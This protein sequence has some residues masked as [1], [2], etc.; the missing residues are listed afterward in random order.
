MPVDSR[1][2]DLQVKKKQR[3]LLS[4]D[5]AVWAEGTQEENIKLREEIRKLKAENA[6]LSRSNKMLMRA[7]CSK[8]LDAGLGQSS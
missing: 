2:M 4:P 6:E 3:D 1:P 8:V 7:L 5:E